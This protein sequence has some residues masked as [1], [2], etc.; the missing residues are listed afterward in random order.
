MTV[1]KT[2][3]VKY[4]RTGC[5]MENINF[6]KTIIYHDCMSICYRLPVVLI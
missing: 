5:I 2:E 1:E 4:T 6:F 3:C